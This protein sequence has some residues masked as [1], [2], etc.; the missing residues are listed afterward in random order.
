MLASF[1]SS[2][3][4]KWLL[5]RV[6]EVGGLL[7]SGL[8]WYMSLSPGAQATIANLLQHNWDKVSLAALLP[9]IISLWGYVWSFIST[10]KPH[11]VAD[12]QSKPIKALPPS[13]QEAVK[14]SMRATKTTLAEKLAGIFGR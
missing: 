8:G 2:V 11:V 5:R 13:T 1:F 14:S 3:A 6:L 12:G 7:G 9:L 4:A 10:T